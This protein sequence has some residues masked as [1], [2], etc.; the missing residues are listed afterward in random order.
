MDRTALDDAALDAVAALDEVLL[1]HALA[2][3]AE[4][5]EAGLD[6]VVGAAADGDLEL[7][8]QRDRVPAYEE[9]VIYPLGEGLG[10]EQAVYADGAF[11]GDDGPDDGARAAGDEARGLHLGA[12]RLQ[13]LVGDALYFYRQPDS[14]C[15]SSIAVLARDVGHHLHLLVCK[16]SVRRDDAGNKVLPVVREDEPAALQGLFFGIGDFQQIHRLLYIILGYKTS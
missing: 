12:K 7:V 4:V 9:L 5:V 8:R 1:G 11:A 3:D 2:V 6:A 16:N 14:E 13:V 15:N 10:I